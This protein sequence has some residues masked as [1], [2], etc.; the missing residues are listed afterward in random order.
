MTTENNTVQLEDFER[1]TQLMRVAG[2]FPDELYGF[3]EE[4]LVQFKQGEGTYKTPIP[5]DP[6]QLIRAASPWLDRKEAA[7][8]LGFENPKSIDRLKDRGA[9]PVYR[10]EKVKRPRFK[11][12]DLDALMVQDMSLND[13]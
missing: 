13:S 8:Y 4:A 12:E 3:L 6:C 10:P 1:L 2:G 5:P 11:R 9:L 7:A